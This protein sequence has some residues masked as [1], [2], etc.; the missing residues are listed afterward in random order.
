MYLYVL[1]LVESENRDVSE[2]VADLRG[3]DD[4]HQYH[5]D[6]HVQRERAKV[7]FLPRY[8]TIIC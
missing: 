2:N 8:N 1:R 5:P 3:D 4:Q 7:D 6:T